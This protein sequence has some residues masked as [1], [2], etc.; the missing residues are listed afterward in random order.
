MFHLSIV[1]TSYMLFL[2]KI[3]MAV[4]VEKTKTVN[5]RFQHKGDRWTTTVPDALSR[6]S[7]CHIPR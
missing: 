7:S 4:S 2:R 1:Y 5:I 3:V 6:L